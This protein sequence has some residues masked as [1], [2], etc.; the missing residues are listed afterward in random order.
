MQSL[1]VPHIRRRVSDWISSVSLLSPTELC[2]LTS[3]GVAVLLHRS[4][5]KPTEWSMIDKCACDDGSTLY[6]ST[7]SGQQWD[8]LV[9]FTGTALGLLL[10]WRVAGDNRGKVLERISAHNGVIFSIACD[11]AA[12]LLTTTSDDRSVKFWKIQQSAAKDH[13]S[14]I[15]L[16]EER[17]CFGHTARVFQCRIIKNGTYVCLSF[18]GG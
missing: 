1:P 16:H 10:I 17:Y 12:G 8:R 15:E 13:K 5:E 2:L 4:T 6:C 9:C 14:S 11:F 18:V 3:H 7:L